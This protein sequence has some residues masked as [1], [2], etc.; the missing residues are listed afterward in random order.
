MRDASG[1]ALSDSFYGVE[2]G[3]LDGSVLD[4]A[5]PRKQAYVAGAEST[6]YTH[7]YD[8]FME[9]RSTVSYFPGSSWLT[10]SRDK[11]GRC[12]DVLLA[13]SRRF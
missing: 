8:E 6:R 11:Q 10:F 3:P 1:N 13:S 4:P 5:H 2:E 7:Q 12:S 9:L